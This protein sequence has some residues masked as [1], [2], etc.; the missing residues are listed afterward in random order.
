MTDTPDDDLLRRME[1]AMLKLPK[2]QR[3]IFLAHRLN[4]QSYE[5]IARRTGISVPQVERHMAKAIYKLA[6]QM[7]GSRLR[8]W[9]RWF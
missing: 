7:D 2:L 3:E 4:G 6:K 1:E 9:E 8:W 5:E